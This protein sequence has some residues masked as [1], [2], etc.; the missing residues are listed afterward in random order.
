VRF[1][2]K[3]PEPPLL[4]KWRWDNTGLPQNLSYSNIPPQALAE[5]RETLLREQG[6]VCAY[7]MMRIA[8]SDKGHIEHVQPRSRYPE[9]DLEY[10]N[11]VYCAP[12][13]DGASHEFGA[14]LKDAFDATNRNF[15]SP[16][17]QTC[18]TRLAYDSNGKVNA[19]SPNDSASW[20]TI[21]VL[22][23]NHAELVALRRAAI[24]GLRIF[25]RAAKPLSAA[26]ARTL[27]VH[28]MQRDGAAK[29]APF[30]IAIKQVALHFAKQRDA[31][32]SGIM[33]PSAR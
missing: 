11:M 14:K 18:E 28:V 3:G 15:V 5:L 21:D 33:K 19:K 32:A 17:R 12:G 22:N 10:G 26:E 16:L 25:R 31:R 30:C 2:E 20:K 13:S 8:S 23:L 6:Y 1:I 24:R 7:T 27:A 29:I 4:R 9:R